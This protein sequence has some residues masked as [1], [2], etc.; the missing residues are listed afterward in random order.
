MESTSIAWGI[1]IRI[2]GSGSSPEESR[3]KILFPS[4]AALK[5]EVTSPG[6]IH[7]SNMVL[8]YKVVRQQQLS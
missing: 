5:R 8:I 7:P 1:T 4:L 3:E 2:F 6:R